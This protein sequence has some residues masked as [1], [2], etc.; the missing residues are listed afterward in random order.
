MPYYNFA[1]SNCSNTVEEK[2]SIG[3]FSP[4]EALCACGGVLAYKFRA[5][6]V[7]IVTQAYW[8]SNGDVMKPQGMSETDWT[9]EQRDDDEGYK[10][11]SVDLG[12]PKFDQEERADWEDDPTLYEMAGRERPQS[13]V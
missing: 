12:S 4:S 2:R 1:C 10:E 8:L 9:A 11:N 6:P 7:N 5:H 3:D 13:L